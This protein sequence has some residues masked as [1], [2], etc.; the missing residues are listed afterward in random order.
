MTI[1]YAPQS[2]L[3]LIRLSGAS[4]FLDY[5]HIL[6]GSVLRILL[7]TGLSSDIHAR[8]HSIRSWWVDS[9]PGTL[10]IH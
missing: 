7:P 4:S 6:S 10:S 8:S 1:L 2:V 5:W 3:V 9:P